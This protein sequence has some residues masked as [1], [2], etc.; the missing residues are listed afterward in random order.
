MRQGLMLKT[1]IEQNMKSIYVLVACLVLSACSTTTLKS[2]DA[3]TLSAKNEVSVFLDIH[4]N[5]LSFGYEKLNDAVKKVE[6]AVIDYGFTIAIF[7]KDKADFILDFTCRKESDL[8][9][10]IVPNEISG[11]LMVSSITLIPTY[12]PTDLWVDMSVYD[13][14]EFDVKK[15]D[16]FES[17]FVSQER[18]V[19]APFILFK[20]A[21]DF[22]LP[23]YNVE[24]FYAGLRSSIFNL[25]SEAE[26]KAIFE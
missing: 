22:G 6:Q 18:V 19:W 4:C 10:S 16:T 2:F 23:K 13:L 15:V 3:T 12:W 5:D 17:S 20:L 25:L 9:L 11:M 14:R 8:N 1:F 21:Y 26:A 7:E 24:K